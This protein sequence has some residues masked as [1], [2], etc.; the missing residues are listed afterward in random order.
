MTHDV[1]Y[2]PN[3]GKQGQVCQRGEQ[4]QPANLSRAALSTT[5]NCHAI[6]FTNSPHLNATP[7]SF[8]P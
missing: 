1:N 4:N 7:F 3:P 5:D 6:D 8:L 2:I